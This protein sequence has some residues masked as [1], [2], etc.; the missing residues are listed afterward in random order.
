M[1]RGRQNLQS[2][3]HTSYRTGILA[4]PRLAAAEFSA[5]VAGVRDVDALTVLNGERSIRIRF[6]AIGPEMNQPGC[7]QEKSR[8]L[9]GRRA[10]SALEMAQAAAS[11]NLG[12]PAAIPDD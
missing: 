7:Q 3:H 1:R 12:L 11:L 2:N 6:S 5:V 4:V 10:D 8:A 9:G